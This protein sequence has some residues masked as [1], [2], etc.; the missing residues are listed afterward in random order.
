METNTPQPNTPSPYVNK[1]WYIRHKGLLAAVVLVILGA[2]ALFHWK[3]EYWRRNLEISLPLHLEKNA[4]DWK[5]YQNDELGFEF[6]YEPGLKLEE[7]NQNVSGIQSLQVSLAYPNDETKGFRFEV[8]NP[9]TGFEGCDDENTH[10]TTQTVN[11]IV[12]QRQDVC[13]ILLVQFERDEDQYWFLM[14]KA[15]YDKSNFERSVSTFKFRD[16]NGV[17]KTYLTDSQEKKQVTPQEYSL[18]FKYYADSEVDYFGTLVLTGYLQRFEIKCDLAMETCNENTPKE[19]ATF[20]FTGSSSPEIYRYI[21]DNADG[22]FLRENNIA[23]G[24]YNEDKKVIT[25]ANDSNTGTITNS[26]RGVLLDK[27]LASSLENQVKVQM[28]KP[29]PGSSKDFPTCY[30]HFRDFKLVQ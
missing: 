22:L 3:L 16:S 17:A 29:I 2:G 6:K 8:N 7:S 9:G 24:C 19:Y 25:S 30:S 23:L 12:M 27:L 20:T 4:A 21:T 11:G 5:T 26:I 10:T 15:N 1:S 14:N 18:P 13:A 28:T